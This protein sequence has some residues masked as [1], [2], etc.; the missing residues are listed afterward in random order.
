MFGNTRNKNQTQRLITRKDRKKKTSATY[1]EFSAKLT[2]A[3][4][5]GGNHHHRLLS[6]QIL[7][8]PTYVFQALY[9]PVVIHL[10]TF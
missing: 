8:R 3:P 1:I 7:L 2:P 10:R 9:G 6:N 5:G 4:L